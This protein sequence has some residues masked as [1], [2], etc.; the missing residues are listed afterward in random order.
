MVNTAIAV[1]LFAFII[2]TCQY[3]RI[4]NLLGLEQSKLARVVIG[5]GF[6]LVDLLAYTTG[7][8]LVL[9][10]EYLLRPASARQQP[11]SDYI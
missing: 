4:V 10:A 5:T 3:F 2:E 11:F 9:V 7:F 6:D 8:V 1:L